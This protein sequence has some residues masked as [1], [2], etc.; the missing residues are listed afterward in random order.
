[1]WSYVLTFGEIGCA[2]VK[3]CVKIAHSHCEPVRSPGM[4]VTG[5]DSRAVDR[6]SAGKRIYP[7]A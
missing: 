1:M 5:V 3:R 6:I 4:R 7:C 2:G